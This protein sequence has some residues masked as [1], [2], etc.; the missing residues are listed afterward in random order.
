M[1]G[2]ETVQSQPAQAEVLRWLR[3]AGM[4]GRMAGV[5]DEQRLVLERHDGRGMSL[6][7]EA[8]SRVH[9]QHVAFVPRWLMMLGAVGMW[10]GLRVLTGGS[11][12]WLATVSLGVLSLWL[13]G[14]RSM[15][16]IDT[17]AGDRHH[18]YGAQRLLLRTKLLL[19]RLV[20]GDSLD[21]AREAVERSGLSAWPVSSTLLPPP[22]ES[23][24]LEADD[25][26]S[27]SAW[28]PWDESQEVVDDV[29][30]EEAWGM[31]PLA[32]PSL[33]TQPLWS[34]DG[35]DAAEPEPEPADVAGWQ[36]PVE[37]A[38]PLPAHVGRAM[39]ALRQERDEPV[40]EVQPTG[41]APRWASTPR[42]IHRPEPS[43]P[44]AWAPADEHAFDEVEWPPW[45]LPGAGAHDEALPVE[46]QWSEP[47]QGE[48]DEANRGGGDAAPTAGPVGL[49]SVVD[50]ARTRT[51]VAAEVAP[52]D[53][54]PSLQQIW[55]GRTRPARLEPTP[56]PVRA[57]RSPAPPPAPRQWTMDGLRLAA[58]RHEAEDRLERLIALPDPNEGQAG[59]ALSDGQEMTTVAVPELPMRFK[60]F[61]ATSGE[62][63]PLDLV[64]LR[65]F[66]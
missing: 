18:V 25:A 5:L 12:L 4:E 9:H 39:R 57:H 44:D 59:Q 13:V 40:R 14:R 24:A 21:E 28:A 31:V 41:H 46:A 15:L 29:S 3:L 64:G 54:F 37:E 8:I 33:G 36:A 53:R 45:S 17:T 34:L 66:G 47:A 61:M 42:M 32:L 58:R 35:Q 63:S 7:L 2:L 50:V 11:G 6:D 49:T 16:R 1:T 55:G 60:E 19:D 52:L 38:R 22:A 10:L 43:T 20:N 65:R 23:V 56:A 30:E 51:A 27:S 48:A 62:P 26:S